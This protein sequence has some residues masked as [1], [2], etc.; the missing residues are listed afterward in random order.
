MI[1]GSLSD[2]LNCSADVSKRAPAGCRLLSMSRLKVAALLPRKTWHKDI[3]V[4]LGGVWRGIT[5]CC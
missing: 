3:A 2:A 4:L 1:A 5:V